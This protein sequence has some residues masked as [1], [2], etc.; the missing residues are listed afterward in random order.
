MREKKLRKNEKT[1]NKIDTFSREKVY[2]FADFY[3]SVRLFWSEKSIFDRFQVRE[4]ADTLRGNF[5]IVVF[6]RKF[7]KFSIYNGQISHQKW[8]IFFKKLVFD[9]YF[10]RYK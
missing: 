4:V 8:L 2:V 1:Q 10:D 9:G 7:T 3:N 6:A 5:L